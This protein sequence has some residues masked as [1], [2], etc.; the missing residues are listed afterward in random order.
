MTKIEE[1]RNTFR[2][3]VEKTDTKRPFLEN[4]ERCE[5]DICMDVTD[6]LCVLK[7]L[8]FLSNGGLWC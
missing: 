3:S 2:I 8:R 5:I 7:W 1:T 6:T 4:W